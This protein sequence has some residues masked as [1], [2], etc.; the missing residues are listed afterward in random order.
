M[1]DCFFDFFWVIWCHILD[2]FSITF[3]TFRLESLKHVPTTLHYIYLFATESGWEWTSNSCLS[4]IEIWHTRC[5]GWRFLLLRQKAFYKKLELI[6]G[7][8]HEV[9]G[10]FVESFMRSVFCRS[11]SKFV[12]GVLIL[13]VFFVKNFFRRFWWQIYCFCNISGKRTWNGW[14]WCFRLWYVLFVILLQSSRPNQRGIFHHFPINW[15]FHAI[16]LG[17]TDW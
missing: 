15:E 4:E 6:E 12:G 1:I 3:Q 17:E 9:S 10:I 14:G 8:G 16:S 13:P 5:M 11:L 7:A 2:G